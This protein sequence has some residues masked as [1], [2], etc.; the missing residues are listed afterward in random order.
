VKDLLGREMTPVERRL[1][2]AYDGLLALLGEPDLPPTT[3]AN[4]KEAAAALYVAVNAL[5][6]R[7]ARPDDLHL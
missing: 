3:E 6:L 7:F 2:E 1:L 4:V 5:G